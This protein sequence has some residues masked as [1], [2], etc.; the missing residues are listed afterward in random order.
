MKDTRF[1]RI[2][3]VFLLTAGVVILTFHLM[4]GSTGAQSGR[5]AQRPAPGT[6]GQQA[7]P[8]PTPKPK[9]AVVMAPEPV[10]EDGKIKV[11]TTMVSI[12]AAV[13]NRE[14]QYVPF[15]K[16]E[17]F[18]IFEEGVEQEIEDFKSVNT[19]FHVVLLLDTSGS[20]WFRLEDIQ[21]AA[22]AFVGQLRTDDRV[23]VISFDD[24]VYIDSEFTNDRA[25]LRE[26]I[27][28]TKTG[29][30]T[31]LHDAIELAI[32]ERLSQIQGRKAI[33][34]FTDGWDTKSRATARG[35]VQLV[36]ESDVII[37]PVRYDT[38]SDPDHVM[39]GP[40]IGTGSP[41]PMPRGG[42]GGGPY[43]TPPINIPLPGGGRNKPVPSSAPTGTAE[44]YKNAARYL[45]MLASRSGGR[46]YNADTLRDV[47]QAFAMIAEELRHQYS[48]SYYP[49]N[50]AQD[51][52]WRRIKV[53]VDQP[54]LIVRAREGY[55]ARNSA[56]ANATQPESKKE[57]PK[58]QQRKR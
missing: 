56:Q 36:E 26:A 19:P 8:Q 32:T 44:D 1:I 35:V 10:G 39:N 29:G 16:K 58:L 7:Q 53:R 11:D 51:G 33:V 25:A 5:K 38:Q 30:N 2:A 34:L 3:F 17:E 52:T 6:S 50:A 13:L 14:G 23:M 27:L 21:Q 49:T 40:T 18:H 45:Q 24:K 12:P 43:G 22:I 37:Y 4:S 54:N 20:T 41:M 42:G 48:L 15:L 55:R 9:P 47:S 31:R 57:R 28:R 46:L